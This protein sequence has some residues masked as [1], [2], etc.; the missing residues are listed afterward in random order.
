MEL[1]KL[2]ERLEQ[3]TGERVPEN[4]I[5]KWAHTEK[6]I[7]KPIGGGKGGKVSGGNAR[8]A[9]W[10]PD[11]LEQ[12]AAVWWVREKYRR[13]YGEEKKGL[14]KDHINVIKRAASVLDKRPFAI[15][16]FPLVK[17]PLSTQHIDPEAITMTFV[18]D[19]FDGVNR[20]PGE[21]LEERTL[22]LNTLVV[23][24]VAAREKVREWAY[25]GM[26]ATYILKHYPELCHLAW[27]EID[28]LQIDPWR[29]DLPCPWR[30]DRPARVALLWT[31]QPPKS[32]YDEDWKFGKWAPPFATQLTELSASA[33]EDD[34]LGDEIVIYENG[35]DTREF[36]KIDV[37]DREGYAKAKVEKIEPELEEKERELRRLGIEKIPVSTI[38]A[39]EKKPFETLTASEKLI[40]K[41]LNE[42]V[43]LSFRLASLKNQY[44]V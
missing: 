39:M 38:S 26:S 7:P 16:H 36:F 33:R 23:A 8:K 42:L 2:V 20:F 35:V 30:I 11:A 29:V 13:M 19:D 28:F 22:C 41:T 5:K 40:L 4:T 44:G 43:D 25:K 31:S 9:D 21:K 18:S 37:G 14:S 15:Y 34:D 6:I 17:G 24:W 27:G 32:K 12:A 10:L 3:L 1:K